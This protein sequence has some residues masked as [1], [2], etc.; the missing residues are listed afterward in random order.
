MA[1]NVSPPR[2]LIQTQ[3]S[4][5]Q[6]WDHVTLRA[7]DIIVASWG[8]TG[9]TLTQQM[10]YQLVTGGSDDVAAIEASPW[11]ERRAGGPVE[12]IAAML[13]AQT[14][15]RVMKTHAPFEATPF[16]GT[17]KYIYIGRDA[18]DVAWS[19]HNHVLLEVE[20]LKALGVEQ[21]EALGVSEQDLDLPGARE[22]YLRWLETPDEAPGQEPSFWV[23]AQSW[24]NQRHRSNVLLLHYAHL[25]ADLSS[26]MRRL[27]AFLD[28]PIDEA[29]LPSLVERCGLDYMRRQ[30]AGSRFPP[31][32]FNKGTNGRWQ[33]V[34][35][36]EDV[37]VCDAV[38]G[39][40]LTPDCAHWL[41]TGELP[42]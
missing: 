21:L 10:V 20:Q 41:K 9:T 30:A 25:I 15:R 19:L 37:A 29:R 13:E 33:G 11:I 7:D 17:I 31:R 23:N 35:S 8:K 3:M 22:F 16:L 24:W 5:T 1:T 2:Q 42:G 40:K 32:F 34:L 28:I 39:R 6:R 26:E 4:D 27:A 18:R 36:R 14:H 38:A 12:I